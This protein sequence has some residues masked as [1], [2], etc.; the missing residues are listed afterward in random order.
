MNQYS[1]AS[2]NILSTCDIKLQTLFNEVIKYYDCSIICGYRDKAA[3]DIAYITG[4]SKT[5]WPYSKHNIK[6]SRAVDTYPYQKTSITFD[7]KECIYYAGV[8]KGIAYMLG[9]PI[10]W[11]GDFN[12]NNILKDETFA[13]FGH[14]ELEDI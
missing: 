10:R 4:K 14:F 13:D 3:Q 2:K 11:G 5:A 12:R 7:T 6:P 1:K 8:V 9:I